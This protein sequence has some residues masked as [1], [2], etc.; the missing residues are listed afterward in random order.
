MPATVSTY[1]SLQ[2]DQP[3]NFNN[4]S[5][6]NLVHSRPNSFLRPLSLVPTLSDNGRVSHRLSNQSRTSSSYSSSSGPITPRQQTESPEFTTA[7][8]VAS[9][10]PEPQAT[11]EETTSKYGAPMKSE[12][13]AMHPRFARM[14]MWIAQPV[15]APAQ[16]VPPL[17]EETQSSP[18]LSD[19]HSNTISD[20]LSEA[21]EEL[22]EEIVESPQIYHVLELENDL[23]EDMVSLR[24]AKPVKPHKAETVIF[25]RPRTLMIPP[26]PIL[27]KHPPLAVPAPVSV[28]KPRPRLNTAF[29]TPVLPISKPPSSPKP[30][31]VHGNK[32]NS[33]LVTVSLPST[34]IVGNHRPLPSPVTPSKLRNSE[35]VDSMRK[36]LAISIKSFD[37]FRSSRHFSNSPRPDHI[38]RQMNRKSV[39]RRKFSFEH[40]SDEPTPALPASVST[41]EVTKV[42]ERGSSKPVKEPVPIASTD[43]KAKISDKAQPAPTEK[44][45]VPV[46]TPATGKGTTSSRDSFESFK[47]DLTLSLP[48]TDKPLPP[49]DKP[50][51]SPTKPPCPVHGHAG[52][53]NS[54][55]S[56]K[57]PPL[58]P[59]K[60]T[61]PP[62]TSSISTTLKELQAIEAQ[63]LD[64][65]E[66]KI[67]TSPDLASPSLQFLQEDPFNSKMSIDLPRARPKSS[68]VDGTREDFDPILNRTTSSSTR[69]PSIMSTKSTRSVKKRLSRMSKMFTRRK[70]MDAQI[71]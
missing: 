68:G 34:P 21:D 44:P 48:A 2:V 12:P 19:Q 47:L 37:D 56:T 14:S 3:F 55:W 18:A 4:F 17:D 67:A 45:A 20:H 60:M 65:P 1:S 50:L 6:R 40:E 54:T 30:C 5:Q 22:E 57:P 26:S 23:I 66:A 69:P 43:T 15:E 71:V 24:L 53:P 58:T 25:T 31:P 59:P 64:Q 13:P 41:I 36:S 28:S 10:E 29:T 16:E 33:T 11:M 8:S 63:N 70:T 27:K 9:S 39:A 35:A 46:P 52:R 61:L 51:P 42:P 7:L 62:R 38:A 32:H 49:T